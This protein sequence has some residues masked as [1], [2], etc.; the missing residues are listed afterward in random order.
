MADPSLKPLSTEVPS[1]PE[2]VDNREVKL[3]QAL[4]THLDWLEKTY[5]Q[6]TELCVA[7]GYF[8]PEGFA[9]IA[10]RLE[11]LKS[12]RLLLGAEPVP[13]PV[14]P[15]RMPGDPLG[16][17]FEEKLVRRELS[18]QQEGLERDRNLMDFAPGADKA[19]QRP[20]SFLASGKIEVRRYEKSFMHGKAFL[21]ATDNEGV[22]AGSSNFTAAGL[23]SNLELNL[24]RYDPTPV[25][26]VRHWF[27][28]L[29]A[30]AVPFDLAKVY[31]ARY[32]AYAPYLI[33]LR[34]L[35]E[36]YK[37]EL[38]EERR[39]EGERIR[40]TTFQT[41]G[42]NRAFRILDVYKGV[43]ISDG[44]GLGKTFVGGEIL[45]RVIEENRQRAL[46]VAP[47]ALRDG[48]WERFRDRHQ[49]YVETISYEELANESQTVTK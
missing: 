4:C 10:E 24:G 38:E 14:K 48:T 28:F 40:L 1:K 31:E 47:A 6:P 37:D 3:V 33:F 22:V 29:W 17:R 49:L 25:A 30:E 9:L 45:R 44:V 7:T 43:L 16:P 21:F 19:V 8:N 35:W 46:L 27:E 26:K 20:L 39:G 32:E 5:A 41:D 18:R 23:T 13:P 12:V 2:F 36:R 34:V 42:I 15:I 11:K